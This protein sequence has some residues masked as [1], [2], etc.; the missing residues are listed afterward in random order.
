MAL[1]QLVYYWFDERG[2]NIANEYWAKWYLLADAITK[3]RTDGALIRLTT[4]IAS[5][6][7]RARRR[8]R[9]QSFM[10]AVVPSLGDVICLRSKELKASQP[11]ISA[12]AITDS[13]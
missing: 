7:I 1:K 11:F 9:L 2:R 6:R 5:G 8:R 3:N 10:R 4:R 13:I 12:T